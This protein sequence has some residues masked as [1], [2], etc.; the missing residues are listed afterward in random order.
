LTLGRKVT[1]RGASAGIVL[2]I[3]DGERVGVVPVP[4]VGDRTSASSQTGETRHS[5]GSPVLGC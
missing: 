3:G 2:F 5:V 1:E 4:H